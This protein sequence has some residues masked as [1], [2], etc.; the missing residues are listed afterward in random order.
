MSSDAR[1]TLIGHSACPIITCL[2]HST[3]NIF[4]FA[5]LDDEVESEFLRLRGGSAL[6]FPSA[7]KLDGDGLRRVLL[8]FTDV[9]PSLPLSLR[10]MLLG[11]DLVT[12]Q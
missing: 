4:L 11:Y 5:R 2:R 3:M 12:S 8:V 9:P 1:R 6:P 7:L 10:E